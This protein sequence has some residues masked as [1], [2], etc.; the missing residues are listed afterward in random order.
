[1]CPTLR[2]NVLEIVGFHHLWWTIGS[3]HHL[4]SLPLE[5]RGKKKKKK[6][7]K[8][9]KQPV[10][11]QHE[12]IGPRDYVIDLSNLPRNNIER[13]GQFT[14]NSIASQSLVLFDIALS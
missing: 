11:T 10:P 7:K 4:P 12:M 13:T 14:V 1:M 6:K 9:S 8:R 2:V 3:T 5:L